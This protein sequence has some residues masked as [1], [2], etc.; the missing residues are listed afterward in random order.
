MWIGYALGA[1]FFAGLTAILAK[2]GVQSTPSSLATALRTVVV[3]VGAWVMVLIVGSATTITDLSAQTWV[4]LALSGLAT[5]ASWLCF[6][7]A[8]QDGPAS[9]VV[10]I[11]KLSIVVTVVLAAM[12]FG[13][14]QS[15]RSM[16]GLALIIAGTLTMVLGVA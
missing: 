2:A 8:M 4:F 5:G 15:R 13:E 3:L 9:V 16:L 14:R 12:F 6:W 7:R 11:D 10:P 1:A